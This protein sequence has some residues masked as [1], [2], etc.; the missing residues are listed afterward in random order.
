MHLWDNKVK[1]KGTSDKILPGNFN[2]LIVNEPAQGAPNSFSI[3]TTGGLFRTGHA[4]SGND[5]GVRDNAAAVAAPVEAKTNAGAMR[6]NTGAANRVLRRFFARF[7]IPAILAAGIHATVLFYPASKSTSL[8]NGSDKSSAITLALSDSATPAA[9]PTQ[10]SGA[11]A[12]T[13]GE[14][15]SLSRDEIA[16]AAAAAANAVSERWQ[17]ERADSFAKH[18][19]TLAVTL[20]LAPAL[21]ENRDAHANGNPFASAGMAGDI[22]GG[23][24]APGFGEGFAAAFATLR[25]TAWTRGGAGGMPAIS[26]TFMPDPLYPEIAR[27]E[28]REGEVELAVNVDAAGRA[29]AVIVAKSSGHN[30]L[31]EA[32]R[33]TVLRQW[34]FAK[35]STTD[36]PARACTVH[37]VFSLDERRRL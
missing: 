33:N 3:G 31:D 37:I 19:E 24:L 4:G 21:Q 35:N 16:A 26:P 2:C 12:T 23:M 30:D 17:S 25:D 36:S 9:S 5:H 6:T 27:R 8:G 15:E 10:T 1:K 32:A 13:G 18:T 28:K 20:S 11:A 7:A 34:R 29:A 22:A 14:R